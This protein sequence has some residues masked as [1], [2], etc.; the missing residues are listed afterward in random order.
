MTFPVDNVSQEKNSVMR[1]KKTIV[2]RIA[3]YEF[4]EKQLIEM[5]LGLEHGL[6]EED[7]LTYFRSDFDE[8]KMQEIRLVLEQLHSREKVNVN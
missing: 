8:R 3:E 1:Q 2:E 5:R 7:V 4:S 6:A